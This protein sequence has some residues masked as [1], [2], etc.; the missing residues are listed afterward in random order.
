MTLT[1]LKDSIK[2][3]HNSAVGLDEIHYEFLKKLLEE[4]LKF[5]L[6][7]FN[8]IWT[9]GNFLDIWRQTTIELIPKPKKTAWIY[10]TTDLSP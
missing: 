3:S 7:N 5:L 4:S 2:K 1:E 6:K 9:E 10:K 8:K